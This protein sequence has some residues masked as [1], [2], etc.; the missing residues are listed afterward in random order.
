MGD[1]H[2]Y[3]IFSLSTHHVNDSTLI[4]THTYGG[5]HPP[6]TTSTN[7]RLIF[8]HLCRIFFPLYPPRQRFNTHFHTHIWRHPPTTHHVNKSTLDFSTPM[9]DFFP[10]Y[11]PCQPTRPNLPNSTH[12]TQLI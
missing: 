2:L 4:F 9:P 12:P 7:Q 6:P 10:L 3:R 1:R 11:P 8:R 5:I